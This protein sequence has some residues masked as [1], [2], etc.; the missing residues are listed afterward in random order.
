MGSVQEVLFCGKTSEQVKLPN[1]LSS[2][3]RR[4]IT[5]SFPTIPQ[6]IHESS[7]DLSLHLQD[8]AHIEI[9]FTLFMISEGKQ[10]RSTVVVYI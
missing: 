1:T 7:R 4:T 9:T 6:Y 2:Q 8:L 5:S 10:S 3:S